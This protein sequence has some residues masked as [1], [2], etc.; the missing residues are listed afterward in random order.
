VQIYECVEEPIVQRDMDLTRELLLKIEAD[1]R[2]NGMRWIRYSSSEELGIKHRSVEEIGYHLKMLIEAGFLTGKTNLTEAMPFIKN[3]TWQ[4]H[5]LLDD[6]RDDTIWG[7]AKERAKGLAG[8]GIGLM[9]EL[10]KAEL[11]HY[12]K[13]PS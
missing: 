9:W 5:E 12:L 10:A 13:L 6:I 4:G 2:L 7:K 8:V 11:K 3:I 1:E